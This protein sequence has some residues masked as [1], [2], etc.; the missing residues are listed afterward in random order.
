MVIFFIYVKVSALNICQ[1]CP[2]FSF[3]CLH[4]IESVEFWTSLFLIVFVSGE[5]WNCDLNISFFLFPWRY[6]IKIVQ[7]H[8]WFLFFLLQSFYFCRYVLWRKI[9]YSDH[10]TLLFFDGL[11]YSQCLVLSLMAWKTIFYQMNPSSQRYLCQH[12]NLCSIFLMNFSY[13]R[14]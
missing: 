4:V 8:F 2:Y 12:L 11:E 13:H 6:V 1:Y 7:L 10:Y 14:H 3:L 9:Y 5:F